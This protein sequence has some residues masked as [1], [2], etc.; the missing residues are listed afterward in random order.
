M[1]IATEGLLRY[2]TFEEKTQ[3]AAHVHEILGRYGGWW[4]TPDIHLK[5]WAALQTPAYRKTET[6]TLGRDLSANYFDDLDHA[7]AFFESCGFAVDSRP[8]L[9]GIRDQLDVHPR[10]EQVAADV[11]NRRIFV[12]TP[13]L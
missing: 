7:Q 8:L 13:K 10:N 4:I 6:A 2:L 1:A 12:L 11:N 9:E 3:L 5:E